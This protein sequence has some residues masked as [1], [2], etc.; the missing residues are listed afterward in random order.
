KP[1]E[2]EPDVADAARVELPFEQ[3]P[4]HPP[5][6]R[7]EGI[8]AVRR[9]VG[10]EQ[11]RQQQLESLRLA[12]AVLATQE[13]APAVEREFLIVVLPEVQDSGAERLETLAR[14]PR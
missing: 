1:A 7:G 6:R 9:E 11:E 13:Q 10:V 2:L 8:E 4:L 3:V 14:G 12:R 5:R